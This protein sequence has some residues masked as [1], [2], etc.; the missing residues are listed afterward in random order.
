MIG[1]KVKSLDDIPEGFVGLKIDSTVYRKFVPKGKM[2]EAVFNTWL[3][4]WQD[5]E[6]NKIRAYKSDYTV[7]GRK[8]FDD[9]SAEVETYISVIK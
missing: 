4:I 5:E 2:S 6:L 8:Y 9:N 7:H 1:V 3:Q